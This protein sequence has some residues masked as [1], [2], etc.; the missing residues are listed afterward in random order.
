MGELLQ[1]VVASN[2]TQPNRCLFFKTH[3]A[4]GLF[5]A[6][7]AVSA[8][9]RKEQALG[10]SLSADGDNINRDNKYQILSNHSPTRGQV[11]RPLRVEHEERHGNSE[12]AIA[13][14]FEPS[15]SLSS[16]RELVT[17]A[18][19]FRWSLNPLYQ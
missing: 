10:K 17:S 9:I 13:E 8:R 16:H 6:P 7:L 5:M 14:R 19:Q 4:D 15:G 2:K 3:L 18:A 1:A 12:H 11:V